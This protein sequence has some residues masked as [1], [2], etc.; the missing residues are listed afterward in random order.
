MKLRIVEYGK[1]GTTPAFAPYYV[2]QQRWCFFF[3]RDVLWSTE[4][5]HVQQ[6]AKDIQTVKSY[7][8]IIWTNT[9]FNPGPG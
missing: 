7:K 6:R 9:P 2:L 4:L 1:T 8:K 5:A 3:W